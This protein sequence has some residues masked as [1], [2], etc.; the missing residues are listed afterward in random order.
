MGCAKTEPLCTRA[1]SARGTDRVPIRWQSQETSLA[2]LRRP[3]RP[4]W[5]I[6]DVNWG[7]HGCMSERGHD[8][9]CWCD[10][11]GCE[12]HDEASLERYGCVAG[13]PYYGADTKFYG[14]DV[15]A[16][17]LP[18]HAQETDG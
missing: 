17:G 10:C 6:A 16:R 5:T 1:R 9:D 13:P 7:S 15:K 2:A 12:P 8:G 18:S 3:Q 4:W 11:C 14:D